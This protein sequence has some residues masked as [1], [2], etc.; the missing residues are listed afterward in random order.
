MK[1]IHLIIFCSILFFESYSQEKMIFENQKVYNIQVLDNENYFVGVN[2]I[3]VHNNS[4]ILPAK[5]IL[6]NKYLN[7]LKKTNAMDKS[8]KKEGDE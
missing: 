1:Y 8:A 5:L 2:K 6:F 7:N 4:Y 3:L